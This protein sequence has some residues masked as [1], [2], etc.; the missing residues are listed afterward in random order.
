[1]R[2]SSGSG[3]LTIDGNPAPNSYW[4]L[5]TGSGAINLSVPTGA[6][7]RLYARSHRGIHCDLPL[8]IEEQNRREIRGRVGDGSARVQMQTGNGAIRLR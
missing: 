1:L 8:M 3:S 5:R 4:D 6:S 2:A 7:F